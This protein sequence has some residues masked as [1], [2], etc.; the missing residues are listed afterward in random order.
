VTKQRRRLQPSAAGNGCHRGQP[1][2][3][4]EQW[5][6]AVAVIITQPGSKS[7][8][9]AQRQGFDLLYARAVLVRQ[10]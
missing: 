3:Q 1:A 7:Q 6:P 8:Q 5:R 10:P 4:V 2:A 9:N